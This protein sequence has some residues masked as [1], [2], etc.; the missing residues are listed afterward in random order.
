MSDN[1]EKLKQIRELLII[2]QYNNLWEHEQ[3]KLNQM[4]EQL[5]KSIDLAYVR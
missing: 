5:I 3:I 2:L 4:K 1:L